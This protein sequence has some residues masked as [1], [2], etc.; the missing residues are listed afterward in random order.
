MR[1]LHEIYEDPGFINRKL[2]KTKWY[3][4]LV[5]LLLILRLG[6]LQLAMGAYYEGLADG[7]RVRLVNVNALRGQIFDREGR[8]IATNRPAFSVSFVYMDPEQANQS[9]ALLAEILDMEAEVIHARI[10]SHWNRLY[11]PV[12][13]VRDVGPQI[14]SRL[15]EQ[16]AE[17]PGVIV[18]ALPVR[19]YPY[20]SAAAH[21]LGYVHQISER[22]LMSPAFFGYKGDSTVGQDGIESIYEHYL[23]GTDGGKQ[24]EVDVR[25]RYRQTLGH[26]PSSPG[27]DLQLTLDM[28]FQ[29]EVERML[30]G[31]IEYL[32][33]RE[34]DPLPT[35]RAGSVVVLDVN[36]GSVLAL[37]NY[38]S[39]DP[40][41][42]ASGISDQ[43]LAELNAKRAFVNRSIAGTYAPGS[44]FKMVTALAALQEGKTT[45]HERIEDKGQH[46]LVPSL[47]CWRAGGHGMVDLERS[48]VVSCNVYYYEMGRRLGLDAIAH[49]GAQL[50]LAG[51][52]G[53]D[54]PGEASGLLPT[55]EWKEQAF[56]QGIV[57][58]REVLLAEHMLAGMGQGFSAFTPLQ[59]AVYTATIA[60]GGT[61][62][63]PYLLQRIVDGQELMEPR[64]PEVLAQLEVEPEFLE[65]VQRGMLGVTMPGGTSS[66]TFA[67]TPFDVAGKTGT[68]ENPHGAAHAW[69]VGYAP[70]DEPSI[71]VAVLVEQGRSGGGAA[72]PLARDIMEWYFQQR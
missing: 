1:D 66:S 15:E 58:E 55:N 45:I 11:Q 46:W 72:A 60:N 40:N 26:I 67:A 42:F 25:G 21:I 38:P 39:Y 12:T 30:S 2:Q 68:A 48:L 22:Q 28:D 49:Y 14:H 63:Q 5:F 34:T 54:L 9:I 16:R 3:L 43:R 44:I 31:H 33:T 47:H 35:V 51:K 17:L 7:N 6:Q 53:I 52:T 32:R 57:A 36:D 65:V 69:F 4:L 19:D 10:Q 37:A 23:A 8:V 50:G 41:E 20:G 61:L 64:E 29:V 71:A 59:M 27:Y 62:Y 24:V 13:I 70:Y 18:E 56:A